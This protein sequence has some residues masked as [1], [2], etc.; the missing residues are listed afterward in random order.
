MISLSKQ[1][2]TPPHPKKSHPL[3]QV[4]APRC[5]SPSLPALVDASDDFQVET[6]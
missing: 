1:Q 2:L 4:S 6:R 3:L 5:A